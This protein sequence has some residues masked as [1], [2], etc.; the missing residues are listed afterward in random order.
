MS[1]KYI[2]NNVSGQ[3]ITGDLTINGNVIITGSSNN[4]GIATYKALLS[5]TGSITGYGMGDFYSGFIIGETYTINVYQSGDSFS[6]IANVISG[7]I[8]T[9]GCV[10]IA[11]GETPSN[12]DFGSELI[13]NGGL[14]VNVL[15]NTLGYDIEWSFDGGGPFAGTYIGF[16]ANTG[17]LYNTFNRNTTYL[18]IGPQNFVNGPTV[19]QIIGGIGGIGN[20]DDLFYV[21]V[22]DPG[23]FAPVND[24]LFY[25][26]FELTMKQD[27]DTTPVVITGN[28]PSFPFYNTAFDLNCGINN[29]QT[30]YT[31]DGT[32]INNTTDLV[33]LLNSNSNTNILGTFSEDG[34]GGIILTIPT[35]LRNQLCANDTLTFEVFND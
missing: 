25:L 26:P 1:T 15:E 22:W 17:P 31:N 2:V 20:K 23:I 3:T 9:S 33:N 12:Y 29:L 7:D 18:N 16:N 14:V 8:N 19:Y 35:N 10:F 21:G 28:F 6:N 13:S 30:F 34:E 5:Q 11:T 27:T 24:T 4:N 32:E